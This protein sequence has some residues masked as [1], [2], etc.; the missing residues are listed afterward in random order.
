[1]LDRTSGTPSA[2]GSR[3]PPEA[4]FQYDIGDAD[5]SLE[6]MRALNARF[7]DIYRIYS[8][9]RTRHVYVINHPD[10]ARRVLVSNHA[11]Y[12]RGFGLD[13]VRVLLGNG[14][15]T[16]DNELWRAQRYMM[17]PLFHR[18]VVTRFG[19]LIDTATEQLM[20]RWERHLAG[21]EPVNVTDEMSEV[22]LE[23]ILRAIF[24]TDLDRLT[25]TLGHNPFW[26]VANNPERNLSFAS[27]FYQLR[28]L[29]ADLARR[30]RA[31]PAEHFDFLGMM[32]AA[33]AKGTGTPMGE[34]ELVD[35]VMTLIIAGHETAA[36]GLN[37]AWYL[38]SQH[39]E[40]EARMHAEID[41]AA[42]EHAPSLGATESLLFTRAV[43]S[44]AL[45]LYPPVWL[46]SRTARGPDVLAGCEIPAGADVLLSPY[47]VH[48]HPEFWTEP[49][50]FRPE[51]FALDPDAGRA[52]CAYIPFGAGPR[53]CI[54]ETLALYEMCMHLYKVARQYRLRCPMGQSI[55][56][57]ALVNLR[58]RAPVMMQLERR[59]ADGS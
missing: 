5:D 57:E 12:G 9:S 36:S 30:R 32:L 20:A 59:G 43:A 19:E 17:Q 41:A 42:Q 1:M 15:V 58:T 38:L 35:E 48:R 10:D 13:R 21:N 2:Q 24:G 23:F 33:R 39:P 3:T 50:S 49:E 28:R 29:V 47:L 46:M 31:D 54:G 56:L 51:R 25:E 11:N 27:Q 52:R 37:S 4:D 55:E 16:S 45:R 6:Q 22:T 34:R 53:H 26:L 14:L 8:P 18:R 40:A 44:E 7:G